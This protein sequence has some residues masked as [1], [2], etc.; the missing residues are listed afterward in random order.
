MDTSKL[1]MNRLLLF[2]FLILTIT[3]CSRSEQEKEFTFAAW[4]GADIAETEE[5]WRVQLEDYAEYGLTDIYLSGSPETVSTV[6]GYAK[7]YDIDIHAWVWTLN[8]PGDTTAAKH[9]E[10]YAVNRN[11]DNSYDYRAYVDYYQW[12]SPFSDG[13]RDYIKSTMTEYAK[14]PGIKSVHLDYVR[15]V[16][17]ILGA[18]LQPKYDLV[19][20]KQFP[21]YDYGYHPNAREGF[22]ELFGVDPMEMEYPELSMEW[23]QYRLNAVTTLVNEIA[24]IVHEEDKMLT[25]A[26]FPFPEMSRQMVRQDWASWDLNIAL[27][28]LYQNFYRQNLEWIKFSAEQGVRESHGR[29]DIVAG[30]YIPSLTPGGLE[31]AIQKAKEG[32]AK[33]V[34]VFDIGAMTDEHWA[35]IEEMNKKLKN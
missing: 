11:G 13:A 7:D 15:Y 24:E 28:M 12:L 27:P 18:D 19:Q 29:F 33:G 22:E 5:D 9:P 14:V 17:V 31:T 6:A 25:A 16:D 35:V 1:T 23:L 32:G 21:E 3:S 8:R 26:V 4:T 20:D 2:A 34:S 30:L 10:W